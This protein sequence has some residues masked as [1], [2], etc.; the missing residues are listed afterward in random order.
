MRALSI[1]HSGVGPDIFRLDG[2]ERI[3]RTQRRETELPASGK[4]VSRLPDKYLSRRSWGRD[5]SVQASISDRHV[6][7]SIQDR[8]RMAFG[9]SSGA[10][11]VA[12]PNLYVSFRHLVEARILRLT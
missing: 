5:T 1:E 10:D 12:K 7:M 6:D 2:M 9:A 3:G 11:V 4:E 8:S